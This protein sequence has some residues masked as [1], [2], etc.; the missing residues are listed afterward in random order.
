MQLSLAPGWMQQIARYNP[1]NWA[2]Q[3]G[4]AALGANTDWGLVL[5][6]IGGLFILAIVC[7]W[8]ST[9]AFRAY[10]RSV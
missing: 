6:R 5:S 9:R 4:R 1:V 7:G 3:A 8:L 10:Q 2:V